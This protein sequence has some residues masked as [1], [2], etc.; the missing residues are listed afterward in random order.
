MQQAQRVLVPLG[1]HRHHSHLR[2]RL[3]SSLSRSSKR[4]V[5]FL[6]TFPTETPDVESRRRDERVIHKLAQEEAAGPYQVV[7]ENADNP[8]ET[9]I[10]RVADSDLVVMGIQRQTPDQ[11][12]LG[13][14]PLAIA[15]HT[16]VPLVLIARRPNRSPI[17]R[18]TG[19]V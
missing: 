9:I 19:L 13:E 2:A 15:Q 16:D 7:F 18:R 5:T 17:L 8:Q 6:K 4:S 1:G 10:K 14:L 12:T 11:P 3:L